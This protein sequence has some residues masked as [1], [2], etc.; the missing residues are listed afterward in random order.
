MT[1]AKSKL[2]KDLERDRRRLEKKRLTAKAKAQALFNINC[3]HDSI[4]YDIVFTQ[5]SEKIIFNQ[6]KL[7][8]SGDAIPVVW[9]NREYGEVI[10]RYIPQM[11]NDTIKYTQ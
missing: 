3:Y 1:R 6:L 9:G 7:E 10:N 4:S 8:F 5:D 11:P 2:V